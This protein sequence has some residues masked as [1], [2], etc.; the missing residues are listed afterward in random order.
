MENSIIDLLKVYTWIYILY[1]VVK[2]FFITSI[3]FLT[4]KFWQFIFWIFSP[5][6]K[7]IKIYN[8]DEIIRKVWNLYLNLKNE[9]IDSNIDKKEEIELNENKSEIIKK[10]KKVLEIFYVIFT[11]IITI[12]LFIAFLKLFIS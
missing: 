12:I 2:I 1:N 3:I 5:N 10:E 8:D 7:Y 6:Y 11:I 4:V 9:K